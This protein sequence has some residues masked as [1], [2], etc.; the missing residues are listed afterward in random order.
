[1]DLG[2]DTDDD[3]GLDTDHP[4]PSSASHVK[5]GSGAP[6]PAPPNGPGGFPGAPPPAQ[7]PAQPGIVDDNV[8]AR[9]ARNA[10]VPVIRVDFHDDP[11]TLHSIRHNPAHN[12]LIEY[13]GLHGSACSKSR[14]AYHG[15][16]K[17]QGRPL[18]LLTSWLLSASSYDSKNAHC[19]APVASCE[20]RALARQR[21]KGL[22]RSAVLLEFEVPHDAGS[23]GELEIVA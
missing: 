19:S 13:C 6:P 10:Y 17:G 5:E 7:N 15:R 11:L 9:L 18:G 16:R 21:F 14:A 8:A 1:M 2:D 23:I 3:I 20:D 12:F 4:Q 22:A